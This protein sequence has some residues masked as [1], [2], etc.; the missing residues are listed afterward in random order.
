MHGGQA[1]T[2][3]QQ[4]SG[5]LG[6]GGSAAPNPHLCG[7]R[8]HVQEGTL[9]DDQPLQHEL[10]VGPAAARRCA[11]QRLGC[12]GPGRGAARAGAGREAR[13]CRRHP[14]A[15]WCVGG[16][17][18]AAPAREAPAQ[19]LALHAVRRRKAHDQ[20]GLLLPDAVAAVHGL[21]VLVWVP[22]CGWRGVQEAS[23]DEN[24]SGHGRKERGTRVAEVASNWSRMGQAPS[25]TGTA[26]VTSNSSALA[27]VGFSKTVP[28][29][30][31][32]T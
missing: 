10:L 13:A 16:S 9:L 27:S 15:G 23:T 22:V 12:W 19:H 28:H 29:M 14:A 32:L 30:P 8:G 6:P 4:I 20:H 21:K 18:G 3:S 25:S 11:W 26:G 17:N 5:Q 2:S 24:K 1:A 7:A 31:V